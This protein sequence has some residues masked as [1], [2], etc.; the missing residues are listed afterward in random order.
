MQSLE[1]FYQPDVGEFSSWEKYP[2]NL[3]E[4]LNNK[5]DLKAAFSV[6]PYACWGRG[7]FVA[8]CYSWLL[9]GKKL[10]LK[11]QELYKKLDGPKVI[12]R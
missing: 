10:P 7:E 5:D 6:S 1:L 11:A 9:E 8:E 4:W 12:L 2:K 3:K